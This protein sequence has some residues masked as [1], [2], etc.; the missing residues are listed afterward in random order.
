MIE[1]MQ[2]D[3]ETLSP[4]LYHIPEE[5]QELLDQFQSV[6]EAPSKLPPRKYCDHKIPLLPGAT[7][8]HS[9][10]YRYTLALKD[11]IERKVQDMLQ[12]GVIQHSNNSF[13]SPVESHL[14][15]VN[16]RSLK[17]NLASNYSNRETEILSRTMSNWVKQCPVGGFGKDMAH[18]T[19]S[20]E[21]RAKLYDLEQG[22][23]MKCR[24][25]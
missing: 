4:T 12:A 6:F 21:K 22:R 16:R 19:L 2:V 25:R 20:T 14:E 24:I 5:I 11:E 18:T 10:P 7:P 3:S 1:L 23:I 15:G 17:I 8:V 13:S 9:K